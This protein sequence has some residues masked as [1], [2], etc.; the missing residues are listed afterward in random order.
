MLAS[1]RV[2]RSPAVLIA[3]VF[4]LRIANACRHCARARVFVL[5]CVRQRP[6]NIILL[7]NRV[8]LLH[9]AILMFTFRTVLF[10]FLPEWP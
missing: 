7:T 8:G 3:D 10:I 4:D 6:E 1:A 5:G 9:A 2:C